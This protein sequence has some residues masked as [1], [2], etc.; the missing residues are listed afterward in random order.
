MKCSKNIDSE[1]IVLMIVLL[2]YIVLQFHKHTTAS[3]WVGP[4]KPTLCSTTA[5]NDVGIIT[6]I[7]QMLAASWGKPEA[8]C[9]AIVKHST[10]IL[11][12]IKRYLCKAQ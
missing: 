1:L 2:E 6:V 8:C 11:F 5:L 9:H 3:I 10:C 4:A 12:N 7:R